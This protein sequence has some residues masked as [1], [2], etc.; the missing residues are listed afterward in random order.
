MFS[1]T[2]VTTPV[3]V[4]FGQNDWLA[5]ST[6]SL[7]WYMF[8]LKKK[9]GGVNLESNFTI[10]TWTNYKLI[11]ATDFFLASIHNF[12]PEKWINEVGDVDLRN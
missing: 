1:L 9:I 3:A 12:F 6:V 5:S 2:D 10:K 11:Y 7:K 4:Y 8:C